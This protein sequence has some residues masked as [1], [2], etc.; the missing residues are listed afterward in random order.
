MKHK[1]PFTRVLAAS[2]I[3]A[4][5]SGG[6]AG[7][8]AP[9][10]GAAGLMV[11]ATMAAGC[12]VTIS[13]TGF[14]APDLDPTRGIV[15][16]TNSADSSGSVVVPSSDYAPTGTWSYTVPSSVSGTF[17]YTISTIDT[18]GTSTDTVGQLDTGCVR[19]VAHLLGEG[20][21]FPATSISGEV[22]AVMEIVIGSTVCQL[23]ASVERHGDSFYGRND[24]DS[25]SCTAQAVGAPLPTGPATITTGYVFPD[26][27]AP[28][29]QVAVFNIPV[30]ASACGSDI[31]FAP[32]M[33]PPAVTHCPVE[34][35]NPGA[36]G[37]T[38]CPGLVVTVAG[39]GE[40]V[41]T[42]PEY[43][44][45][46]YL[47]VGDSTAAYVGV[48]V[49]TSR[50]TVLSCGLTATVTV[51]ADWSL[52]LDDDLVGDCLPGFYAE[53]AVASVSITSIQV[54]ADPSGATY[55][56]VPIG[57]DG[58][59]PVPLF[60]RD[61]TA[62]V[63]ACVYALSAPAPTTTTTTSTTAVPTTTTTTT[64]AQVQGAIEA[65]APV[66]ASPRYTG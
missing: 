58:D 32:V 37:D 9:P 53:T 36:S 15:I 1:S 23:Y 38:L 19:P 6:F 27:P 7:L 64:T 4:V 5:G 17:S 25:L 39:T 52:V 63:S 55:T 8:A 31:C 21:E 16:T 11:S 2:L 59:V 48:S 44:R 61:C 3:A 47:N 66:A 45:S 51:A 33:P 40:S 62:P 28:L 49:T 50:G 43:L 35:D 57:P 29:R 30:V 54:S 34:Q 65:A 41:G 13:G 12:K 10:A 42:A 22:P 26:R 24:T 14:T 20:V 18:S 60:E 56:Y 46:A